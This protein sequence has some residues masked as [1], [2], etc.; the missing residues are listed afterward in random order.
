MP[1]TRMPLEE[2]LL[3]VAQILVQRISNAEL[4]SHCFG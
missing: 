4:R 2:I 3:P 1:E